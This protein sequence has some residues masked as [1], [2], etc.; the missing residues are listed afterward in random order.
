MEADFYILT[1][2][3]KLDLYKLTCILLFIVMD[4]SRIERQFQEAMHRAW[5]DLLQQKVAEDPPDYDWIVR[6]YKEVRDRLSIYYRIGSENYL[7]IYTKMDAD[8][9]EQMIRNNAFQGAEFFGLINYSFEKCLLLGSPAR[10]Q[11]TKAKR[12]AVFL[13]LNR[14]ATFAELVPL[15]FLNIN[16]CIDKIDEDMR[17][18]RATVREQLNGVAETASS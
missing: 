8:L 15:Y 13:A 2:I 14:G 3:L 7:E 9:F 17:Q 16:Q 4:T 18:F 5:R 11:D 6:L 12:D 10:D 1:S